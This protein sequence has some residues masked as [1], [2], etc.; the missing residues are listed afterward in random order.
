ML[1]F[2]ISYIFLFSKIIFHHTEHYL[3][4]QLSEFFFFFFFFFFLKHMY[5][6]SSDKTSN[7]GHKQP[8]TYTQTHPHAPVYK[9]HKLHTTYRETHI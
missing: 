6:L 8:N 4:S 1:Y 3:A 9:L 5:P 7:Q 2:L